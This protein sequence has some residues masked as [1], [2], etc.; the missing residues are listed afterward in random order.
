MSDWV[1]IIIAICIGIGTIAVAVASV[2]VSRKAK[3]I[4]KSSAIGSTLTY[5][6]ERYESVMK[7]KYEATMKKEAKLA[8]R[9]FREMF[10]LFWSETY[11]W[12]DGMIPDY[13]MRHWIQARASSWEED[14]KILAEKEHDQPIEPKDIT[15]KKRWKHARQKAF[16]SDKF[17]IKFMSRVHKGSFNSINK[18][19]ELNKI[20]N[21]MK[22]Q[23]KIK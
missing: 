12:M 11:L 22:E 9:Y 4:A 5:C 19:A 14:D 15:Y 23:L 2:Y 13:I 17:F 18:A 16:K 10:D 8:E 20:K 1:E 3:N 21:E 7:I 6:V